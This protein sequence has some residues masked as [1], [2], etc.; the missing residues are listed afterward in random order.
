MLNSHARKMH[1]HLNSHKARSVELAEEEFNDVY[2]LLKMCIASEIGID[3]EPATDGEE[4]VRSCQRILDS[5]QSRTNVTSDMQRGFLPLFE[6]LYNAKSSPVST[7][8]GV[9]YRVNF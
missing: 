2:S 3:N 9:V 8:A 1:A 5:A 4:F 7:N 6:R